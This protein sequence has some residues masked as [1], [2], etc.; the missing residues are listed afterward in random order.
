MAWTVAIL[1]HILLASVIA[2]RLLPD[3]DVRVSNMIP[4]PDMTVELMPAEALVPAVFF[5]AKPE[6]LHGGAAMLYKIEDDGTRTLVSEGAP[7]EKRKYGLQFAPVADPGTYE[8]VVRDGAEGVVTTPLYF[9]GEFDGHFPSG[10]GDPGGVYRAQFKVAHKE[11]E[12]M[13]ASL[14]DEKKPLEN[15][16]APTSPVANPQPP[17]EPEVQ[18]KPVPKPPENPVKK[19][20]KKPP[21]PPKPPKETPKVPEVPESI[22]PMPTGEAVTDA[23]SPVALTPEMLQVSAFN[24][25]PE[26]YEESAKTADRVF[27]QQDTNQFVAAANQAK[28]RLD[29][30]YNADGPVIKPGHEGNSLSHHKDVEEYLADMHNKIHEL[31]AY[32]FLL[33]LDTVYREK[34]SRMNNVNMTAVVEITMDSLG[35]VIDVRIVRSSGVMEYDAEAIHVAWNSSPGYAPPDRMRSKNGKSYIH[36]T[37]WR[38]QRQCGVFGVKVFTLQGTKQEALNYSLKAVNVHEKKLGMTPSLIAKPGIEVPDFEPPPEPSTITNANGTQNPAPS[39]GKAAETQPPHEPEPP[40][41][42]EPLPAKLN[43]LDD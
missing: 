22:A 6:S 3:R 1:A 4:A 17:Q 38:D 9:D 14:F 27:A 36:W 13:T 28:Q 2:W 31:W 12:I 32:G 24:L 39:Q 40:R 37:F 34:A 20:E 30:A 8:I 16:E 42:P 21:K 11:N 29:A 35:E 18:P 25:A 5:T 10:N 26:L 41:E 33:R 19:P 15:A 23:P 43:P 7:H